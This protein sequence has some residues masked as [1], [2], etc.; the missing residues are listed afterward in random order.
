LEAAEHL[1]NGCGRLLG[2]AM[3]SLVWAREAPRHYEP[4]S[5]LLVGADEAV[6]RQIEAWF[7]GTRQY[8]HDPVNREARSR[9]LVNA[10]FRREELV[11][12]RAWYMVEHVDG[13]RQLGVDD[14][15]TY[16]H[17][18]PDGK[19]FLS[20]HRPWGEPR[21]TAE[22]QELLACAGRCHAWLFR[23][24]VE[25]SWLGPAGPALAPRLEKVLAELLTGKCEGEIADALGLTRRTVHKYVEMIYR[26]F[27]VCTRAELMALYIVRP[28]QRI[29]SVG[30][31]LL[32]QGS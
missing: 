20:L 6:G 7:Y 15:L 8:V 10:A 4:G 19:L 21:F 16:T 12:D 14:V 30:L 2:A 1:L 3:V 32:K 27:G 9:S 17:E 26:Q 13:R 5:G 11:E 28:G 22:E 25:G 24:L 31:K 23:S 18:V 29:H